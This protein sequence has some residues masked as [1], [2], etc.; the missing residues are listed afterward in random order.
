MSFLAIPQQSSQITY[1][2]TRST[3]HRGLMQDGV[4]QKGTAISCATD[5]DYLLA[6][7]VM[8]YVSRQ[9]NWDSDLLFRWLTDT[10]K[11]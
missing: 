11:I 7:N 3:L 9:Y 10:R 5:H 8:T 1:G 2:T 6:N 4:R